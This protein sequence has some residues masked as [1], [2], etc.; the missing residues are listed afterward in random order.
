[1]IQTIGAKVKFTFYIIYMFTFVLGFLCYCDVKRD[2]E[3]A[4]GVV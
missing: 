1:M 4:G 3:R 2:G